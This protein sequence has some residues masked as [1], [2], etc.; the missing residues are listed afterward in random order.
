MKIIELKKLIANL[1]D[2]MEVVVSGT[3]HSYIGI[4]NGSGVVKAET[5]PKSKHLSQYYD[6]ENKSDP[7]N[8]VI[9]VFWIDDG[10]Y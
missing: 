10:K 3:D 6:D 7:K 2:N 9:K 8:K 5:F 4:D 1:P